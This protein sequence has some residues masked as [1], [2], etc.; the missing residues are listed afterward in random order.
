MATDPTFPFHNLNNSDLI[1]ILNADSYHNFPLSVIEGMTYDP[2]KD[3]DT[4]GID[5]SL[6]NNMLIEP[7]CT[8]YFS[9]TEHIVPS[10]ISKTSLNILCQNISSVPLHLD[11]LLDQCLPPFDMQFHIIGLCE[12][13]LNDDICGIYKVKDYNGYFKNKN[14]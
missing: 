4:H 10:N 12:T 7:K 14:M 6:L 8:Y 2:V 3:T 11:I 13:R 5:D 9:D 1:N